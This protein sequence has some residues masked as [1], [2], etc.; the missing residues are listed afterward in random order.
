MSDALPY[1][2]STTVRVNS[3]P[4]KL[5]WY[6][7][8]TNPLLGSDPGLCYRVAK[9]MHAD[10]MFSSNPLLIFEG[11]RTCPTASLHH[12][13]YRHKF[14]SLYFTNFS[15]DQVPSWVVL[16]TLQKWNEFESKGIPV[17]AQKQIMSRKYEMLRYFSH[18]PTHSD[19][20]CD[21]ELYTFILGISGWPF[22][23]VCNI[24]KLYYRFPSLSTALLL[25]H[26]STKWWEH[27][28]LVNYYAFL[29]TRGDFR[30]FDAIVSHPCP[31]NMP[32]PT[33]F[34]LVHLMTMYHDHVDRRYHKHGNLQDLFVSVT[35]SLTTATPYFLSKAKYYHL[36]QYCKLWDVYHTLLS[37]SD[38][39]AFTH[40]FW[41]HM[42]FWSNSSN[43]FT[44][45]NY[46]ECA[47]FFCGHVE[48]ACLW[49]QW[50]RISSSSHAFNDISESNHEVLH[51]MMHT[52]L[53]SAPEYAVDG[54]VVKSGN[55]ILFTSMFGCD[56]NLFAILRSWPSLLPCTKYSLH[57]HLSEEMVSRVCSSRNSVVYQSFVLYAQLVVNR[58]IPFHRKHLTTLET[59][60]LINTP[61]FPLA[62]VLHLLMM[63][64][65]S[66][67]ALA[68]YV[69]HMSHVNRQIYCRQL[70]CLSRIP[71]FMGSL[72]Q[73]RAL[74]HLEM[75][76]NHPDFAFHNE[77]DHAHVLALQMGATPR[78]TRLFKQVLL[79][80]IAHN[81][82]SIAVCEV[83]TRMFSDAPADISSLFEPYFTTCVL[84][85]LHGR[86]QMGAVLSCK[87]VKFDAGAC[88]AYCHGLSQKT[89]QSMFSF[90]EDKGAEQKKAIFSSKR[91]CEFMLSCGNISPY[92]AKRVVFSQPDLLSDVIQQ[93][94]R[95]ADWVTPNCGICMENIH[96]GVNASKLLCHYGYHRSCLHNWWQIGGKD[97]DTCPVC[98]QPSPMSA[99]PDRPA[100]FEHDCNNAWWSCFEVDEERMDIL[101]RI[102]DQHMYYFR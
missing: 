65:N 36:S 92:C 4:D 26:Q 67:I 49:E 50:V 86:H 38:Q 52:L 19:I 12:V 31:G 43:M 42:I 73:N 83:G 46:S 70:A 97:V 102:C 29:I 10:D 66:T 48:D 95:I 91:I 81:Q 80:A 1:D 22:P 74:D 20:Y 25:L 55:Y 21:N 87:Y 98:R 100:S 2:V 44:R 11:L 94:P 101:K 13:S 59:C 56:D 41:K 34:Q 15:A 37:H 33:T 96:T 27:A 47:L 78:S 30:G 85:L 75:R 35:N 45:V 32:L 60:P 7:L 14:L 53:L 16:D 39:K 90:L 17:T 40:S 61:L 63:H 8:H 71:N 62:S 72:K 3:I 69:R 28:C 76:L 9:A 82:L 64:E 54:N 57:A 79:K 68:P 93:C 58:E 6:T 24:A 5:A 88:K 18:I 89:V 23:Y 84:H 99:A 51:K 77:D